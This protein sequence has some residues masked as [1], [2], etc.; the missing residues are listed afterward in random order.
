MLWAAWFLGL[1]FSAGSSYLTYNG[2]CPA[3][4]RGSSYLT[5]Q[6]PW[7]KYYVG[8]TL[9]A[10][11]APIP[12]IGMFAML[13][14]TLAVI[15]VVLTVLAYVLRLRSKGRIKRASNMV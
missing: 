14:L 13:M 15:L 11:V 8:T 5:L 7:W 10:V 2:T 9:F 3:F 12:L 6:C 1:L 4:L